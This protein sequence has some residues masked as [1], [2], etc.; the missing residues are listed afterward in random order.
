MLAVLA[1]LA[2]TS[3]VV[4]VAI[5]QSAARD[6]EAAPPDIAGPCQPWEIYDLELKV[7]GAGGGGQ[8]TKHGIGSQANNVRAPAAP[9]QAGITSSAPGCFAP[10]YLTLNDRYD[11]RLDFAV[12]KDASHIRK[13]DPDGNPGDFRQASA[14]DLKFDLSNRAPRQGFKDGRLWQEVRLGVTYARARIGIADTVDAAAKSFS[15]PANDRPYVDL[16]SDAATSHI[17]DTH[18]GGNSRGPNRYYNG[19]ARIKAVG[20]NEPPTG[21]D[22]NI[23]AKVTADNK[24]CVIYN[25]ATG[26]IYLDS[27]DS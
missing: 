13:H 4:I 16:F 23:A 6:L 18:L 27:R 17:W 12:K 10:C 25:A 2:A 5:A 11:A 15:W 7:A 14:T 20:Y 21:R 3:T 8:F 26:E 19:D 9:G 22:S 1:L 24:A